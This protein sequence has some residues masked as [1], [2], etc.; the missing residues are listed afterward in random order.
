MAQQ[1][2]DVVRVTGNHA[3]HPGEMSLE[4][5]PESVGVM[6][7]MINFIVEDRISRPK[8]IQEHYDRLPQRARDA[9]EKRD[10]GAKA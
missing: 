9:I 6:F 3:V 1:A 4:D 8:A 2:L 10:Q 7:E 5:D